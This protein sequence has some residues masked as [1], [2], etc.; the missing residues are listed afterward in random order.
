MPRITLRDFSGGLNTAVDE[1]LLPPSMT[2]SMLNVDV[3]DA[4]AITRRSGSVKVT[5]TPMVDGEVLGL[6]RY[7]KA[8][9][10]KLWVAV[11]ATSTGAGLYYAPYAE[12]EVEPTTVAAED[13]TL[14]GSY[15]TVSD[16]NF[17]GG[18]VCVVT[19]TYLDID[20]PYHNAFTIDFGAAVTASVTV[21]GSTYSV[22]ATS[23]F[24]MVQ[25]SATSRTVRV[26][27][28]QDGKCANVYITG[29]DVSVSVGRKFDSE[30]PHTVRWSFYDDVDASYTLSSYSYASWYRMAL[31]G[32]SGIVAGLNVNN[33]VFS[34]YRYWRGST[35]YSSG[36]QR[37]QGWHTVEIRCG[38][39]GFIKLDG[40]TIYSGTI[41]DADGIAMDCATN[42]D[43]FQFWVDSVYVDQAM[44]EDFTDVSDW[45]VSVS[46]GSGGMT[47]Q[48]L[49][50]PS[51]PD[52]HGEVNRV[53][54]DS[55][56]YSAMTHF[57]VAATDVS[58]SDHVAFVTAS[59]N[60]YF[61]TEV[62]AVRRY[63]GSSVTALAA[64]APAAKS[65]A[66]LRERI[67]A[68][69]KDSDPELLEYTVTGSYEDWTGGGALRT[70]GKSTGGPVEA[71]ALHKDYLF[72]L[73]RDSIWVLDTAGTES[74][75]SKRLVSAKHGCVAPRSVAVAP[76]GIVFLGADAVYFYG[77][78]AGNYS[79]DG[80]GFLDLSEP[81]GPT[82]S[83]IANPQK[84]AG[85]YYDNRYWLAVDLDGDGENETVLV[86]RM[87]RQELAG[88]WTKYQYPFHISCFAVTRADEYGLFAGTYTGD[89]YKLDTGTN[90]AGESIALYY[91]TPPLT[92]GKRYGYSVPKHF[93]NVHLSTYAPNAQQLTVTPITDDVSGQAQTVT[94]TAT[95]DY[96]PARFK[97]RARGRSLALAFSSSGSDQAITIA[98]VMVPFNAGKVR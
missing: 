71:L 92:G 10:D 86:Y 68:A 82:I 80:S 45:D 44:W 62:D 33:G 41:G 25:L 69:G 24:S 18:Q 52:D 94:V 11:A 77:A 48:T 72:I 23:T 75:W 59:D 30:G 35:A 15:E 87:P 4:A 76:N 2:A 54:V 9:G 37:S 70:A 74:E 97:L 53:P 6:H 17:A 5:A 78:L 42:T 93:H 73:A 84:A 12:T 50:N 34:D 31:Y 36:I 88:S 32:S 49:G 55:V 46:G 89:V 60:C 95:T 19:G 98:E 40:Q 61:A 66:V 83:S 16:P 91:R 39:S 57:S 8:D 43:L 13:M 3:T 1:S 79:W 28:V 14:T 96:R 64:T 56:T 51:V 90:D 63:D 20:I 65:L 81:I 7:Y 58:L 67:F 85:A 21:D 27:P 29:T 26:T 47:V 22:S 38:T